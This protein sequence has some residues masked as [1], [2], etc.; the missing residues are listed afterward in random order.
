MMTNV[1][2][3]FVEGLPKV[4][5]HVHVEA[6]ISADTIEKLAD[7][8]NVPMIRPK[9]ELFQYKSL[10]EFLSIY[11]W[12]VD[13]LRS[14]EIAEQIAYSAARQL[15]ADGIAYAEIF[16]GPRY[17]ANLDDHPQIEA[18]CRGFARAREDGF[19][20]CYLIPSISREQ[21]PEWAMDLV[22]WMVAVDRVVGLGLD[23]N[24]EVLGRTSEKFVE[25]FE[26]A[27]ALG[28]G[29]SAHCGE[30]AGPGSVR[31]GLEFLRLDRVDHGVRAIEDPELVAR[32]AEEK[33]P[34]TI[35]P[36]SNVIIGLHKSISDGPIDA[37]YK[38][39]V[40]VTVNSDDP[41]SMNVSINDEFMKLSEA[42]NWT[43]DDVLRIQDHAID[44]AYC[45]SEKK[46]H[47]RQRQRKFA[48]LAGL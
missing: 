23:G 5:L 20:D 41:I 3:E 13:L 10:A 47:L 7:E 12:W 35:C 46:A 44:A 22:D 31:D 17:W 8:L 25:V 37:M 16:T 36:T 33:V 2:R 19:A 34:L 27:A 21:A 32:L 43:T 4:E 9:S 38:A 26:R 6:C 40:P 45:D 24:E 14:S 30:S 1:T 29:R 48:M 39:G 11:E 18:L 42:F 28:L 15:H